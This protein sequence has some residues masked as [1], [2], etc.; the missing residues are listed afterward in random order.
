MFF[1]ARPPGV[2]L[3][4]LMIL[5]PSSSSAPTG[6]HSGMPSGRRPHDIGSSWCGNQTIAFG[7][8]VIDHDHRIRTKSP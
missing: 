4:L 1:L 2:G 3:S 7:V 5:V 8:L 6:H